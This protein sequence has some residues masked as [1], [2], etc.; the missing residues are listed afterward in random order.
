[1]SRLFVPDRLLFVVA[2]L[3]F[4]L[5]CAAQTDLNTSAIDQAVMAEMKRQDLVGVAIGVLRGGKVVYVKGYGFA[6]RETQTPVTVDTVF[7]WASN[8]KPL[9][10]VRALQLMQAG[11][12]D[13]DKPISAYISDLASQL[14]PLTTRQLL[15]H[16][17]GIPHY[18]NGKLVASAS[19]PGD[20]ALQVDPRVAVR[21]FEESP[22][23][24][25]PGEKSEYSSHAYVLLSAV[26]QAAGGQPLQVQLD[27]GI[28]EPLEMD[29]F[30]LDLPRQD[31]PNWTSGYRR[32]SN[33]VVKI[34]DYAHFWKHGAGGYK[35][36]VQ[37]FAKFANALMTRQLLDAD[38]TQKMWTRQTLND[39]KL[40]TYGLGVVVE[41]SGKSLKI[42]HNGSQDE[43]RTRMVLYPAQE[44]GVVVMC[45]TNHAETGRISTAIYQAINRK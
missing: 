35:S 32:R 40:A 24:F 15:F 18:R 6:D 21:R 2:V 17:S 11:Q 41:G 22:L 25:E 19:L 34:N 33:Q 31:Q 3:Y 26:V 45:N 16:A 1:M 4:V 13:I 29:S 9:I 42:S 14:R 37:D 5:P 38:T 39:G 8:S 10:A 27:E 43:T 30:Q 44:H 23:I 36:N 12:L 7:N 20:V 28:L